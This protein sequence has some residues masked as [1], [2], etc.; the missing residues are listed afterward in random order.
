[1]RIELWPAGVVPFVIEGPDAGEV[2][3]AI[4]HYRELGVFAF[5]GRTHQTDFLRFVTGRRNFSPVGKTGGGQ[6]VRL[7]PGFTTG[8]VLHEIGH[9][10]GRV[11]EHCRADRDRY[12]T[13]RWENIH[14]GAYGEFETHPTGEAELG[15]YDYGS[16]MHY[17]K[18]HYTRN[19]NRTCEPTGSLRDGVLMGQRKRLSDLDA[20]AFARLYQAFGPAPRQPCG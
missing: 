6:Q 2:L 8:T 18:M 19:G 9:A 1:M 16:I 13:I 10:L 11:H 17:S 14:P 15:E 4:D 5:V 20:A 7:A 3:R 12:V